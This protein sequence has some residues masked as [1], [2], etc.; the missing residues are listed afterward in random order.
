MNTAVS[1]TL[2]SA[3]ADTWTSIRR[4]HPDVPEVVIALGAGASKRGLVL[5]HFAAGAWDRGGQEVS[6]LFVGGEGLREGARG[7]L[8]TLLHEGGHGMAV[9]RGVKDTSRQGRYHNA[10][11]RQLAC[12]IGLE[13]SRHEQ[14][15]WSL[16]ALPASTAGTYAAEL[17]QLDGALVAH[18][19]TFASTR[20]GRMSNGVA[21]SCVCGR[22]LRGSLASCSRGPILCGVCAQPFRAVTDASFR[23]RQPVS[24]S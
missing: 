23:T 8:I 20:A 18:R 4:R 13:V 5:G 12:E 24:G 9:T 15:G 3:L 10:R 17:D 19:R 1:T 11:Y 21:L 22:K 14:L 6:E 2:I 7:V 16:S